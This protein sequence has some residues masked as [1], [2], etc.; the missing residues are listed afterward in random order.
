MMMIIHYVHSLYTVI[1][2]PQVWTRDRQ[3]FLATLEVAT[4][5]MSYSYRQLMALTNNNDTNQ[6]PKSPCLRLISTE[7]DKLL[8]ISRLDGN[9]LYTL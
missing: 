1:A 6:S 4:N 7:T 5:V 8:F 2:F 9:R 3:V